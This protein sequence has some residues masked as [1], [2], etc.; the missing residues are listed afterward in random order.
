MALHP[1]QAEVGSLTWITG[2]GPTGR[3]KHN[4]FSMLVNNT[5]VRNPQLVDLIENL[6]QLLTFRAS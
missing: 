5:I 3:E 4:P 2:S 6:R 1:S